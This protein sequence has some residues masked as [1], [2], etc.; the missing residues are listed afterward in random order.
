MAPDR[1]AAPGDAAESRDLRASLAG[2]AARPQLPAWNRPDARLDR[3]DLRRAR[4]S[5]GRD[6][7]ELR[8]AARLEVRAGAD[9]ARGH[10]HRD[11]EPVRDARLPDRRARAA[12]APERAQ[13]A[14]RD[15]GADRARDLRGRRCGVR[16]R[17][18]EGGLHAP[19]RGSRRPDRQLGP[20]RDPP[21]A[22]HL[23]RRV[24]RPVPGERDRA[25]ATGAG[26]CS[27]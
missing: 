5:G 16:G 27:P 25:A 26:S 21:E 19:G 24:V 13:R 4:G 23:D 17:A 14:A 10:D 22:G 15:G 7:G 20:P 12:D 18:R 8:D 2:G 11:L 1:R 3:V 6:G 9:R